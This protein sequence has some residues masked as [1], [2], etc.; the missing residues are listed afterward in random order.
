MLRHDEE[1]D[2]LTEIQ[3]ECGDMH[4]EMNICAIVVLYT[5]R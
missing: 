3:A 2:S 4:S 5:P 1:Q